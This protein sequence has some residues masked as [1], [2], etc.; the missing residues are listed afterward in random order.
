[1]NTYDK[2]TNAMQD[3]APRYVVESTNLTIVDGMLAAD[4]QPVWEQ[5]IVDGDLNL[6]GNLDIVRLPDR[7]YVKGDLIL[8]GCRELR[9]L[10]DAMM[11]HGSV[12]L[13]ATDAERLPDAILAEFNVDLSGTDYSAAPGAVQCRGLD[14]DGCA[15]MEA[16]ENVKALEV[17]AKGCKALHRIENFETDILMLEDAPIITLGPNIKA[18]HLDL[19]RCHNLMEIPAN[20]GLTAVLTVKDCKRLRPLSPDVWP[21]MIIIDALHFGTSSVICPWVTRQEAAAY[22]GRELRELM[23][24]YFMRDHPIM[25]RTIQ[26]V[27]RWDENDDTLS[28]AGR[29]S[30]KFQSD[31]DIARNCRQ[32]SQEPFAVPAWLNDDSLADESLP[33]ITGGE[34]AVAAIANKPKRLASRR[35]SKILSHERPRLFSPK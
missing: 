18:R 34:R 30:V 29:C 17:S 5:L 6:E 27:Y 19:A 24:H 33:M 16:L 21:Y 28:M 31:K 3:V 2:I 20:M 26:R 25:R 12:D 14:L 22:M 9:K 8:K 4:G 35:K 23:P 32:D 10:P 7:L 11:V 1:M 15:K 13:T